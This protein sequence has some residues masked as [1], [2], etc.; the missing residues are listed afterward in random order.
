MIRIEISGRPRGRRSP[1]PPP[2][3]RLPPE[4]GKPIVIG[5]SYVMHS[6]VLNADRRVNIYLPPDYGDPKRSFP[7]LYL[8]DGGEDGDFHHIT[9]LVAVDGYYGSYQEMIVVGIDQPDRRHDLT[10]P[11]ADPRDLKLA[12]TS[13][14]AAGFR[15]FLGEDL[16]PWVAQH[17]RTDGHSALIGE[18]LAGLFVLESFL[19]APQSFDD[20]ISVSP[21]LWWNKQALSLEA[22]S[23]LRKGGFTG[24]RLWFAQEPEGDALQAPVDRLVAALKAVN[25][26]GLSWTYDPRPSE[27]HDTIYDPVAISALRAFYAV[28]K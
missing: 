18:S 21:S 27:R 13:G 8:L 28:K 16:K 11:S 15:R 19:Q 24:K 1:P 6:A 22:E 5:Q 9:G 17:Y 2:P 10:S 7:V 25:P 20:Y 12:P 4:G 26:S 23:D 14:G 3:P